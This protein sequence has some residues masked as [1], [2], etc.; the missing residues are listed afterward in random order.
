MSHRRLLEIYLAL[1]CSGWETACGL[2]GTTS[3]LGLS[4]VEV[5][6]IDQSAP[7]AVCGRAVFTD[8][9]EHG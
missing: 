4:G 2:T 7:D 5:R 8:V 9:G 1:I 6:L 3:A